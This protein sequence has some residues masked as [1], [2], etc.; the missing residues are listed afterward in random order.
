MSKRHASLPTTTTT[1]MTTGLGQRGL[2]RSSPDPR[3][4]VVQRMADRSPQVTRTH[5]LQQRADAHARAGEGIAGLPAP[6]AAGLE[7]LSGVAMH[8]VEVHYGSREPDS[9]DAHAFARGNRIHL[10]QG[11]EDCLPHE[12]WHVVQ[13][14]Q[15]RV[16][17]TQSVRGAAVNHDRALEHEASEMGAR[18]LSL[19]AS[20]AASPSSLRSGASPVAVAQRMPKKDVLASMAKLQNANFDG[21]LMKG[22]DEALVDEI[23]EAI[24]ELTTRYDRGDAAAIEYVKD[25]LEGLSL[26]FAADALDHRDPEVW[27]DLLNKDLKI[28]YAAKAKPKA[29]P[30][31]EV[32]AKQADYGPALAQAKTLASTKGS[33]TLADRIVLECAMGQ[34][35]YADLRS[36]ALFSGGF[37]SCTPVVLW[38]GK[39]MAGLFHWAAGADEQAD[40]L[41]EVV[42]AV[43]PT[44]V[45]IGAHDDQKALHKFLAKK[46]KATFKGLARGGFR[47]VY[48]DEKGG[49]Q[50]V[51]ND[52][53]AAA[54]V[55]LTQVTAKPEELASLDFGLVAHP[56]SMA[57]EEFGSVYGKHHF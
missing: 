20:G 9:L 24:A 6:L 44:H 1:T 15:G 29:K 3:G 41:L 47:F 46:I 38:N 56:S 2:A 49:L 48:L 17:A 13:Q 34:G 26:D 35:I 23:A 39:A 45:F 7:R 32:E 14:K 42:S 30:K 12:A 21:P 43:E 27:L 33:K 52:P 28:G 5:H 50:I 36:Y 8:D 57:P 4:Q 53:K 37:S 54:H 19:G 10:A 22:V 11:R 40:A 51:N 55:D 18:A 16:A 31:P 25:L